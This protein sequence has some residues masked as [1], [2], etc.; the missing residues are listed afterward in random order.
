MMIKLK[1][2][3]YGIIAMFLQILIGKVLNQGQGGVGMIIFTLLIELDHNFSFKIL[4]I[5]KENK[6][7]IDNTR[8]LN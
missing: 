5:F 8:E 7:K 6:N 3:I 2:I 4:N 1:L